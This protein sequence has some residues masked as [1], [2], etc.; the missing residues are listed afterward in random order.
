MLLF[1]FPPTPTDVGT[2]PA[3]Y[4]EVHPSFAP[5]AKAAGGIDVSHDQRAWTR[6]EES[7]SEAAECVS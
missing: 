2:M 4:D 6:F 7:V 1:Y 3:F 5:D